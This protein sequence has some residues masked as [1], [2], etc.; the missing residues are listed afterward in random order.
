MIICEVEDGELVEAPNVAGDLA[1]EEVTGEINDLEERQGGRDTAR[2]EAGDGVPVGDG[3]GGE[4]GEVA[5]GRGDGTGHVSGVVGGFEERVVDVQEAAESDV[6]DAASVGVALDAVPVVA[7]VGASP[8]TEDSQVG[9]LQRGL[10]RHQGCPF[11]GRAAL[12][13]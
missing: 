3:E 12:N 13:S 1:G 8:G 9:L 10:Q 4:L 5:D 11:G 7:T 2:D 6:D